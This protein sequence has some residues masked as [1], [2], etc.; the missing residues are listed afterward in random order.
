M[1]AVLET[2]QGEA[3][4]ISI[5]FLGDFLSSGQTHWSPVLGSGN[6]RVLD[7]GCKNPLWDQATVHEGQAP[8]HM[9][10]SPRVTCKC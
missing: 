10:G 8:P 7:L 6:Q 3:T 2:S 1:E 4:Y 9:G 5:L